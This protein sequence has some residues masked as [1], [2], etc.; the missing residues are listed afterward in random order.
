VT[1]AMRT[2]PPRRV[3]RHQ[4]TYRRRSW[5]RTVFDVIVHFLYGAASGAVLLAV[6]YAIYSWLGA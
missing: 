5:L 4:G 2:A 3:R 6:L 1:S